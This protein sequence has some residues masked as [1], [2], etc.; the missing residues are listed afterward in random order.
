M[1]Q[2]IVKIQ[3]AETQASFPVIERTLKEVKKAL[4]ERMEGDWAECEW[5]FHVD[6]KPAK[7]P[8]KEIVINATADIRLPTWPFRKK[9]PDDCS[10]EWMRM[11]KALVQHEY[12]HRSILKQHATGLKAALDK[13]LPRTLEE[14][15]TVAQSWYDSHSVAQDKHDTETDHGFKKGVYLTIPGEPKDER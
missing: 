11:L 6:W 8:F 14:M 4:N 9:A 3:Y 15:T 12:K 5:S 7:A 2:S 10:T 1:A 13:K